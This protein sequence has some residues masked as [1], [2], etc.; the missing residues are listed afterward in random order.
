MDISS[1][2]QTK[3]HTRSLGLAQKGKPQ[4]RVKVKESEKRDKYQDFARELKK[5]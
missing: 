3:S 4:E 5:I 1:Y 2:K